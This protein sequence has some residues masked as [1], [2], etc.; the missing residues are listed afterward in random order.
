MVHFYC[1]KL[2]LHM[3][4]KLRAVVIDDDED[5]LS[6]IT[7]TLQNTFAFDIKGF[8]NSVEALEY[9]L[10]HA[11][12]IDIVITDLKMPSYSGFDILERMKQNPASE[13]ID[14]IVLSTSNNPEDISRSKELGAA[15]FISKPHTYSGYIEIIQAVMKLVQEAKA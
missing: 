13:P 8:T 4:N 5:D 7:E 14:V 9:I 1:S 12:D 6:F 10:A 15:Q 3:A 11:V 2:K